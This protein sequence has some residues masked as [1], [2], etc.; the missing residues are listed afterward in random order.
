MTA[1]RD[2]RTAGECVWFLADAH[3]LP[4]P[5]PENPAT[6]GGRTGDLL[7]LLPVLSEKASHL[8]LVG[9]IFDFW[10]EYLAGPTA[11]HNATLE[12]IRAVAASGVSV[13]FLGG[14]HDYWAGEAFERMT[15]AVVHRAPVDRTHCGRRLFIAHGDGL[16]VGDLRYKTLRAV[17]RS[18][19]AIAAFR[20]LPPSLGASIGR[21][22]SGLSEITEDR[23]ER[24][25]PPMK[26]FLFDKVSGRYDAAVVGHLHRPACW[27]APGGE[28]VVV[29]DWQDTRAVLRLDEN[30]FRHFTWR[31]GRL[32][33]LELRANCRGDET[34]GSES[35]PQ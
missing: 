10:F 26:A 9:D 8:Y 21:W 16:P 22:A 24:A 6:F 13:H 29:G 33:P 4:E 2:H 23:I 32:T 15:G 30:G 19:P 34:S 35:E 17:I 31:E 1:E 28:A 25:M 20:A 14:N 5:V 3:L 11:G 18:A 7:S 12:A 27:R